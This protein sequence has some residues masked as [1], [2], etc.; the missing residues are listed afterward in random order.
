MILKLYH[1]LQNLAEAHLVVTSGKII[2]LPSGEPQKLRL[3]I[4]D[5]TFLDVW[6]SVSGKY[7]YHWDRQSN[8]K[9]IYRFDNAPHVKWKNVA[10]FPNHLHFENEDNVKESS[11]SSKPEEAILEVLDFVAA[12]LMKEETNS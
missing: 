12:I 8:G 6:Y 4:I 7:A 11:I 3:F 2:Y 1:E 10:T 9:G 5:N